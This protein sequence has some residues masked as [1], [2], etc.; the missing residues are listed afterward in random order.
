MGILF[1]IGMMADWKQYNL[2]YGIHPPFLPKSQTH[3]MRIYDI[4]TSKNGGRN[5]ER[6]I[7]RSYS[8]GA[9]KRF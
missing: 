1:L 3:E 8:N 4:R 7:F 2:Y 5:E 9:G 6:G